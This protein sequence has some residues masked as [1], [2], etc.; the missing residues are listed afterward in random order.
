MFVL[1]FDD[2]DERAGEATVR[3]ARKAGLTSIQALILT[4]FPGSRTFDE[5][6]KA[7]RILFRDW[8]MYDTHHV[9]I[10]HPT[11]SAERLQQMQLKAH[12]KFYS[13]PWILKHLL[14]GKLA[15]AA[16]AWY[17]RMLNRNWTKDNSLYLKAIKLLK[18]SKELEIRLSLRKPCV[19]E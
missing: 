15:V 10:T 2:D 4:P 7:G 14:S 17:A 13:P 18:P 5:M 12:W 16:I 19:I 6:E 11:L 9:V 8:A 1:G 3:Y